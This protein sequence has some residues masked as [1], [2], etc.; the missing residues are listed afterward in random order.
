MTRQQTIRSTVAV[1]ALLTLLTSLAVGYYY[2]PQREQSPRFDNLQEFYTKIK[3]GGLW[4][5]AYDTSGRID[6]NIE[7]ALISQVKEFGPVLWISSRQQPATKILRLY[8]FKCGQTP[9]WKDICWAALIVEEDNH[10]VPGLSFDGHYRL[11]G[12]IVVAGDPDLLD[13]IEHIC[14]DK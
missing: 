14:R 8:K 13:R 6:L 11:W 9:D 3:P 4:T 7:G 5:V 2:I 1:G 12:N 10:F